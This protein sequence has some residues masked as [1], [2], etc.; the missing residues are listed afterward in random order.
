MK[1]RFF[2]QKKHKEVPESKSLAPDREKIKQLVCKSY[3]AKEDNLL[4]S[5]R[6]S[7]N[8]PRDVAIYLTRR[9]RGNSL[10]EICRQYK[11]SK[12]SSASSVIE[13]VQG[14]ISKNRQFREHVEKL[15]SMITKSQT[16]NPLL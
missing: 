7:F 3:H 8:E 9:L 1:D 10:D 5:K 6:G 14:N 13:R 15:R 2:S 11:L 16:E 12:Y 4:K